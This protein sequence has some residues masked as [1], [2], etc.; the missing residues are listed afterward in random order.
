MNLELHA[1][2]E[3]SAQEPLKTIPEVQV[4]PPQEVVRSYYFLVRLPVRPKT[5]D[6][7]RKHLARHLT[8]VG[9]SPKGAPIFD[10]EEEQKLNL[11]YPDQPDT[12]L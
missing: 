5:W 7:V 11:A 10:Y 4:P 6:D 1:V 9:F 12:A 2:V 8:P 3:D